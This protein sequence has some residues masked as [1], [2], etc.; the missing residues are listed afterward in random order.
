MASILTMPPAQLPVDLA[1]AKTF[2][3]I[4]HD[5]EDELINALVRS[6]TA[7]VETMTGL[8]LVEQGWSVFLDD[9]PHSGTICL[10]VAPVLSVED[11]LQYSDADVG[12]VI[13]TAHYYLDAAS[14]PARLMLRPDRIWA[15]PGRLANGIEIRLLA[16][17]G[18]APTNVP[19]ELVQ[20]VLHLAAHW[21]ENREAASDPALQTMPLGVSAM[22]SAYRS[23]R[24]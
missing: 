19:A 18:P 11:I 20:A 23:A 7:S 6:A 21:F 4:D 22:I 17:F 24:I 5:H 12:A 13:D 9:W 3:R 16:G 8:R 1:T 10:P 2:L 14:R 15:R